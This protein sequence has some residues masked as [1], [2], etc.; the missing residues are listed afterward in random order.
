M[1]TLLVW[2]GSAGCQPAKEIYAEFSAVHMGM[3]VRI[4]LYARDD[5][6]ARNAA[7]TAFQ[8]IADL[9]D[10]LSRF[11]PDNELR[12]LETSAGEWIEVGPD[13]FAVL[14]RA[15][16]VA[17]ASGGAFDPTVAPLAALWRDARRTGTLPDSASLAAARSLVNW[18][19][20]Q[21]DGERRAVRLA[22][23]GIRLDLGGIAKGFILQEALQSLRA[24]GVR[25]ALIEAGGDIVVG[26]PPPGE[27]GW[28]IHAPGTDPEFAA[29]AASLANAAIAASGDAA[30]FIEIDGVRYSHIIDP[31]TG[32]GVSHGLTVHVIATDAALADALATALSVTGPGGGPA[33]LARFP[34][35]HASFSAGSPKDQNG[36]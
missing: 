17:A 15:L 28:K 21:L 34:D 32:L 26:D 23:P 4:V 31:R 11:R 8:R 10:A 36:P 25:S 24:A 2:L 1:P 35:T 3:P 14:E 7:S 22:R 20:V 9:E 5:A 29:R 30:Q 33:L 13:L 6:T 27:Q 12:L 16:P 19:M 18:Q